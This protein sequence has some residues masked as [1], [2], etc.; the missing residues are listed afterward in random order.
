MKNSPKPHWLIDLSCYYIRTLVF[1]Q[2]IPLLASFKLSFR[3]NLECLACPFHQRSGEPGAHMSWDTAIATLAELKARGCRI[4]IFEGGEPLLWHDGQHKIA[5]LVQYARKHFLRV[6]VTTNG[7]LPLTV[8]ADIIWVSLDGLRETHNHLRS[9]S[10]DRIWE[11]LHAA[12][13]P[14][15]YAHTTL[16]RENWTEYELLAE[17][18]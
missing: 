14:R 16:H 2:R 1:R 5:D 3:C 7:T 4:V 18:L 10:F 17:Q 12:T 8:P 15:I 13:H 6:A 11:Q 9:N